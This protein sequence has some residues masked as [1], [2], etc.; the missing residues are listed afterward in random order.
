ML[1]GI[2]NLITL[3]LKFKKVL[4]IILFLIPFFLSISDMLFHNTIFPFLAE[5]LCGN[6]CHQ[7]PEKTLVTEIGKIL[8]CSRCFGIYSGLALGT[9]LISVK[10]I[11]QRI[12]FRFIYIGFLMIII[13]SLSVNFFNFYPYSHLIAFI[14]GFSFGF[15]IFLLLISE[16][17]L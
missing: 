2:G 4:L 8:V 1:S 17:N 15:P 12:S 10:K 9:L 13:D 14:S 16:L 11:S 5:L 3:R 7:D 6:V